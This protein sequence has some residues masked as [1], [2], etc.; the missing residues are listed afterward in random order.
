MSAA[1][2]VALIAA[3]S[4]RTH[5]KA[6]AAVVAA[7]AL[8]SLLL[9]TF[10]LVVGATALG[11]ARVERYAGADA[12]VAA[13][14]TTRYRAKPWG[15]DPQTAESALTERIG[16]PW[17]V[18]GV[19]EAVDGVRAAVPD[20]TFPV[21]AERGE[22]TA[23]TG[24]SWDAAGLAPYALDAGREPRTAGEVV[25]P[26]G[27]EASAGDR[28]RLRTGGV[29]RTYTVVGVAGSTDAVHFTADT[30][31]RLSGHP[32]TADA[33]G[34]VAEPGVGAGELHSRVREALDAAKARDARAQVRAADDVTALRV[35][36]G[37]GR[38]SAEQ[39]AAAPARSALLEM[40]GAIAGTLVLIAVL[41]VASLVAQ[42]LRQRSGELALL[43][44]V[45][46]SPRQLRA[47]VG[48]EVVR[49]ALWPAL[50]GA[51]CSVPA[52]FGLLALLRSGGALPSGFEPATPAW[53]FTAVLV[54]AGLT[55]GIARLTAFLGC[56]PVAR[57]RP[58]EA[59]GQTA[60]EPR[61]ER[62]ARRITG[63][64]LLALGISAA[65]T[66]TLQSG[67][68]AAAAASTAALTMVI[69]SAVL[70]PWIARGATRVAAVPLRRFGGP[71]GRL[72][73]AECAAGARRLGAAIT[74]VI[75]VTAFVLVQ[76]A[77][78]AT[79]TRAGDEQAEAAMRA[80]LALTATGDGL[81]SAT[82]ERIRGTPGVAAVN[83]VLRSTVVLA[84]RETGSPRLERLPVIG[85]TPD[86][87]P[88]T[89]D[90]G[91]DEGSLSQLGAGTV[92]VGRD[93]ARSM[94]LHPGDRV[95]IR[96]GDGTERSPR[97]VA[98]HERSLALGDFILPR[99]D[100]ASHM[101]QPRSTEALIAAAPGTDPAALRH[102]LAEVAESAGSS[103][104]TVRQHPAPV[105]L[106]VEDQRAG[107][108]LVGVA[109]T[110]IGTFTV[111]AVLSTLTLIGIGRRPALRLLRLVGAGRTQLRGM[112]RAEA[113][114]IAA[115]GL[116]VGAGVAA[117]PLLAF[118]FA[119][120]RTV[121]YLPPLQGLL[122]VAVVAVTTLAGTLAPARRAV[123]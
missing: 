26:D 86:A 34:L 9:G 101:S 74:P 112:L 104:V 8:A 44:A 65:G 14:Q 117:V 10:A 45:G 79:M 67:T 118:S 25:M 121:P 40:C 4:L 48:R 15:S 115:T 96:F 52:C 102:H 51:A 43:R 56:G 72:A 32:G 31:R 50:L 46:A 22:R 13:D 94:D 122:I 97:I 105:R 106:V 37:D 85:I 49:V 114:L 78:G 90:P 80:D 47:A 109:V 18:V 111:I 27:R 55:V 33:I 83:D 69:G 100:L 119:T 107:E 84:D 73:A 88:R 16:V 110:A 19:L 64:A 57:A 63:L 108:I 30:A 3:R 21:T 71:T 103:G 60:A 54:T 41:I 28:V 120:A 87:L 66:A 98:V 36:T 42:A 39:L 116:V 7:L 91:T 76:L 77:S 93:R 59:L 62:P 6:W 70:G 89:L 95:R 17:R 38:G 1:P 99:D 113:A 2:G 81:P 61:Q 23:L 82:L 68:V 75:L 123:R 5:R 92:S 29:A 24:S 11:H 58:A 35:F 20:S 12:V 53:L